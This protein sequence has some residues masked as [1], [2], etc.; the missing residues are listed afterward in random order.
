[1]AAR[2]AGASVAMT[3]SRAARA[4]ATSASTRGRRRQ[5]GEA[6]RPAPRHRRLLE[7]VEIVREVEHVSRR[8]RG[9]RRDAGVGGQRDED[10]VDDSV[11]AI[12]DELR[13]DATDRMRDR[14]QRDVRHPVRRRR[15]RRERTEGLGAEQNRGT[16]PP[17]QLHGV[18]ETPRRAGPSV[19][20]GGQEDVGAGR[21]SVH[22]GGPAILSHV[23]RT[24]PPVPRE[25]SSRKSLPGPSSPRSVTA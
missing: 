25:S 18:V 5:H 13:V 10:G 7:A 24:D 4:P 1:V 14:H 22:G 17:L 21:E 3:V 9:A 11:S 8:D 15:R 6:V 2:I 12:A 20:G 16:S 19:R 23:E